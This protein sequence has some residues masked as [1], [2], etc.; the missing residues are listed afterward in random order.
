[1]LGGRSR[2]RKGYG[3]QGRLLN[4][5]V[6]PI[7]TSAKHF[8]KRHSF[9]SGQY[10]LFPLKSRHQHHHHP[11]QVVIKSP[12]LPSEMIDLQSYSSISTP[13]LVTN[14]GRRTLQ[15]TSKLQYYCCCSTPEFH[16]HFS[17]K[18]TLLVGM[19]IRII[20]RNSARTHD[21]RYGQWK[22]A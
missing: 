21:F 6:I 1:M 14:M 15:V 4:P 7:K 19:C 12:P 16:W 20:V 5:T 22:Q 9:D 17:M 13:R 18:T 8:S 10:R 11:Q 3:L 2:Q